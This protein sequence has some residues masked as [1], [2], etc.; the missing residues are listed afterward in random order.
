MRIALAQINV[1]VGDI[2]G[3]AD[4]IIT[5]LEK[6]RQEKVDLIVFPEL[7][8]CGYPPKD[9]LLKKDFLAEIERHLKRIIK[10]SSGISAI[11]GTVEKGQKQIKATNYDISMQMHS[12]HYKL[13]NSA[14][15]ISNGKYLGSQ[16]KSYLPNYDIFDEQRYFTADQR[17]YVFK[18]ASLK[19]KSLEKFGITIC[20]D[21]WVDDKI[22]AE[23]TAAGADFI[24]NISSSP[25]YIG[26]Y[27]LRQQLVKNRSITNRVPIYYCNL[28]GGQDDLVFDGGSF[29]CNAQGKMVKM[30][31]RF[32]EDFIIFNSEDLK[33]NIKTNKVNI[34]N[35]EVVETYQALVLGL[36]DYVQKN[37]FNKVILGLSG[38]I[39]SALV[40]CLAVE[41]LGAHRV[42]LV[43]MPSK[44]T[45]SSSIR[46]AITLSQN[47]GIEPLFIPINEINE[48]YL[49]TLQPEF[50]NLPADTTEE[51]IQA[52][53]RGN[54][55]M[56]LSNKFGY[57]VLTTGNKS[58]LS[59]GYSTLYGD[60]AG[61]LALISDVPKM[62]VYKLCRFINELPRE[63][64]RAV[65]PESIFTKPPSAEL[66]PNQKDQDDLP[67]YRILDKIIHLYIEE[68]RSKDEIIKMGFERELVNDIIN[69]ID[70]NE[71]KRY[72][73]PLGI[74]IT[75]KAYGFGRRM[76][77]TNAFR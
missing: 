28:I 29:V 14:V 48:A 73:A 13:F 75:P 56:A 55:L 33:K 22:I 31:K 23:L 71:Y 44:Y 52:R 76:P 34:F 3:N 19:T 24:I 64:Q 51:N 8:I 27:K 15:L 47:L 61:G 4:K 46:D 39:D 26:K 49:R 5:Y 45:Q 37:N 25:F 11:I 16:A 54:I 7:A 63:N 66:R 32:E 77:I 30:A 72:Q 57:L 65:I 70:H 35:D 62:M 50:R 12:P 36:R 1:T 40:A 67:P 53:I 41:A 2:K 38:G 68:N 17:H 59:V 20:E 6:G 74:K 58:E 60:M 21:I 9:L 43:I 69:R 18:I 10:N 42:V